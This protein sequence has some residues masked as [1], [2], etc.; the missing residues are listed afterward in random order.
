MNRAD[1]S[2]YEDAG[3]ADPC[4]GSN[5]PYIIHMKRREIIRKLRQAGFTA[6]ERKNHTKL[7]HPDGRWT[8]IGRHTEIPAGTVRAIERQTGVKLRH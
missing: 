6:V 7:T 2:R 3:V 1:G 4:I 5:Y 8:M